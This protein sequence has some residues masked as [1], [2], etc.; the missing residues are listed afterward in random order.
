MFIIK[1]VAIINLFSDV[2]RILLVTIR[3]EEILRRLIL[4]N[5]SFDVTLVNTAKDYNLVMGYSFRFMYD[6]V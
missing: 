1:S 3:C 5:L 6:E 4:K 2:L